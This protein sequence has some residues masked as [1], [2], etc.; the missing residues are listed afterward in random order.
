MLQLPLEPNVEHY[1]FGTTLAGTDYLIDIRWNA[2]DAAWYMDLFTTD[3]V[4]I[5][6]G[7]KIVLGRFI[8][9]RAGNPLFPPGVF[10]AR[11]SSGLGDEAGL[12]DLGDRVQL[13][14]LTEDDLTAAAEA[15]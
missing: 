12:A 10:I 1:R 14:F 4:A 7:I 9:N 2:R 6:R 15:L 8:G 11:D 5:R 3:E 13:Y